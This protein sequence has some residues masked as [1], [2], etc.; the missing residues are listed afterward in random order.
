MSLHST[1]TKRDQ[2]EYIGISSRGSNRKPYSWNYDVL[3]LKLISVEDEQDINTVNNLSDAVLAYRTRQPTSKDKYLALM[4]QTKDGKSQAE[5][6]H[7]SEF[8]KLHRS[9]QWT[10]EWIESQNSNEFNIT[11]HGRH[12]LETDNEFIDRL[13]TSIKQSMFCRAPANTPSVGSEKHKRTYTSMGLVYRREFTTK[14]SNVSHVMT[15]PAK[16]VVTTRTTRS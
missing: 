14:Y 7:E 1:G 3:P 10:N 16:G 11:E 8:G 13:R 4:R 5:L 6:I 15:A 9:S 12:Y 2:R